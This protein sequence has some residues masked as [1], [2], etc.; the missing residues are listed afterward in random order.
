MYRSRKPSGAFVLL[1]R[2]V[3]V[4][5]IRLH[6]G[7]PQSEIQYSKT[8]PPRRMSCLSNACLE[9]AGV[10]YPHYTSLFTKELRKT[11]FKLQLGLLYTIG[12]TYD[13]SLTHNR[14]FVCWCI[15][16]RERKVCQ[17]W[18]RQLLAEKPMRR[19]KFTY[20]NFEEQNKCA[21]PDVCL[22]LGF[23]LC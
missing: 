23:W 11:V 10:S 22:E 12:H 17:S 7:F 5:L 14:V 20:V 4:P 9:A 19:C 2:A 13:M 8:P 21:S 16:V 1:A 3:L 15:E 6:N 18:K